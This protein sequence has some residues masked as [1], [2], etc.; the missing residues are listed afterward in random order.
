MYMHV[1]SGDIYGLFLDT[2][3]HS[4]LLLADVFNRS[5]ADVE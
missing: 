4:G 2:S 1:N 3:V 5:L